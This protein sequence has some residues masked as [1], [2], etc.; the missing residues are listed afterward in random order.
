MIVS[1]TNGR[2]RRAR[3]LWIIFSLSLVRIAAAA[4]YVLSPSIPQHKLDALVPGTP[5]P[6]T[7]RLIGQP[8][9]VLQWNDGTIVWRYK[10]SVHSGWIDIFFDSAGLY[11]N[12]ERF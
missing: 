10:S 6:A 5:Q 11:Y 8:S 12:Y 2:S 4:T 7:Q 3:L 9:E 1:S